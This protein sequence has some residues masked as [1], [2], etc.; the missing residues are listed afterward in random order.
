MQAAIDRVMATYGMIVKLTPNEE[1]AA[2]ERVMS[3]L[4]GKPEAD[5]RILAI[6]GLRYLRSFTDIKIKG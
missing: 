3:H 2:R 5:E 6:E 1:R 4:A